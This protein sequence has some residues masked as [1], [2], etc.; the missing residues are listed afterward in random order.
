MP[1]LLVAFVHEAERTHA[2][3]FRTGTVP[4]RTAFPARASSRSS[5]ATVRAC[6]T[7]AAE[8]SRRR[9]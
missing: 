4:P 5:T 8:G 3:A 1:A 9:R 2:T 7:F 6:S